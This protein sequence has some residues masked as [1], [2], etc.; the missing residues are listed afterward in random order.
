MTLE[1]T[2]NGDLKNAMKN[3][4]QAALRSIRAIKA[5][6]LLA[7]TDG[8]GNEITPEREI[9]ILQKLVKQ[10]SDSAEIYESNGRNDLATTEKE[11]IEIIK[12]YLPEQ[13]EGE[14]LEK[15]LKEIIATTGAE[16][17]K[18]MGKVMGMANKQLA[19]KADGKS[20][21]VIVKKLLS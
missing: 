3:K 15:I 8:S 5:A 2:L 13:L 10:R 19:G 6:I 11:E 16:S 9:Q 4:D 20:I 14:A 7:K 1:E 18:D 21:S 17:A 12:K